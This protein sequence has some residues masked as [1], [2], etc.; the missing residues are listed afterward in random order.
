[1]FCIHVE[2]EELKRRGGERGGG[3]GEVEE[4]TKS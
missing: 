3:D 1:M 2:G 4:E